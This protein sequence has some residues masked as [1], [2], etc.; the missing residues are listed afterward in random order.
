MLCKQVQGYAQAADSAP[1][2]LLKDG[3]AL[4]REQ[5]HERTLKPGGSFDEAALIARCKA[6]L[7]G[8]KVPARVFCLDA[9][10]STAGPNG[11]KVQRHRLRDMADEFMRL[12]RTMP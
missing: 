5:E 9:F 4:E 7:A 1:L 10:P 3:F 8:F 12:R 6:S 2:R 11:T